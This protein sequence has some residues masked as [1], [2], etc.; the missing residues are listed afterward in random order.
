MTLCATSCGRAR[1]RYSRRL[2]PAE[3]DFTLGL[4]RLFGLGELIAPSLADYEARL[5]ARPAYQRA[6]AVA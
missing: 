4:A 3:R 2:G 1:S 5:Q 6:Y